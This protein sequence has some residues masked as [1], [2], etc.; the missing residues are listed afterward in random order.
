M[1]QTLIYIF[2]FIYFIFNRLFLML[3]ELQIIHPLYSE[4]CYN[5]L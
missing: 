3:T 4:E 5:D 2:H 1:K